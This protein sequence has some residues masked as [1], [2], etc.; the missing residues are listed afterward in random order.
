MPKK[1]ESWTRVGVKELAEFQEVAR[2]VIVDAVSVGFSAVAADAVSA[3][4]EVVD[5][6]KRIEFGS[7]A[8]AEDRRLLTQCRRELEEATSKLSTYRRAAGPPLAVGS[9][10]DLTYANELATNLAARDEDEAARAIRRF[11]T[12]WYEAEMRTRQAMKETSELR[13][14][15]AD[16]KKLHEVA[17]ETASAVLEAR[18]ARRRV[19]NVDAAPRCECPPST[20]A[21]TDGYHVVGCPM[22]REDFQR[23]PVSRRCPAYGAFQDC[24][25]GAMRC[26]TRE[27]GHPDDDGEGGHQGQHSN[28][29]PADT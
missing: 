26:C 1:R 13:R 20:H 27:R 9:D 25:D 28:G 10:E 17:K 16:L 21:D 11:S 19:V 5:L 3:Q 12:C 14:S 24:T 8:H 18:G 23:T 6:K 2:R 4:R 7:A 15:L 22:W 29:A